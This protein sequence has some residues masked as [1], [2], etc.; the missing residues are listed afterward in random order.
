MAYTPLARAR[1]FTEANLTTVLNLY[2]DRFNNMT[3]TD[4]NLIIEPS[5]PG[6]S[7]T[8]YQT[9]GQL[10]IEYKET[11]N[12]NAFR[13]HNYLKNFSPSELTKYLKFWG[14]TYFTP[15]AKVNSS[16]NPILIFVELSKLILNSTSLPTKKY[17]F[18]TFSA[19]YFSGSLDILKNVLKDHTLYI[20]YDNHTDEFFVSIDNEDKLQTLIDKIEEYFPIP[21][22][23]MSPL[24]LFERYS[25]ENFSKFFLNI[26]REP[27]LESHNKIIYG[28]PGTGKSFLLQEKAIDLFDDDNFNRITFYNGYTYGQ[29]VGAF[30][31]KPIYKDLT[32]NKIEHNLRTA[33]TDEHEPII[34]YEFIAGPFIELLVKALSDESSNFCLIIEEIN[35]T[36]VD[37]VFGNIFQL[38]DR[39][40]NGRSSYTIIPSV[41]LLLYIKENTPTNIYN[42]I[43]NNGLYLPQ[44]FYLWATMNSADQGVFPMD[45]A[46]KRRWDFEYIGLN[47]NESYMNNLFIN[48]GNNDYIGYNDFRH[49]VNAKLNTTFNIDEDKM[50]APFFV[51]RRD[52]EEVVVAGSANKWVL[53]EEIFISKI[54][55]YLKDDILR[56]SRNET[57]FLFNTF[58]EI[59]E[60]YP[61]LSIIDQT[62]L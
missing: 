56:H 14:M 62:S 59:V 45:T 15:N 21:V 18:T 32:N 49:K 8:H 26:I 46:F 47:E 28:A 23:Y 6:Y 40:E 29:F 27:I 35:R 54:V 31:P 24:C 39:D 41:E 4:A 55:M 33:I 12:K 20:E 1:N 38:L 61:T 34:T 58:S 57:I 50:I 44:N 3:W 51:N 25:E 37:A 22:G 42:D 5:F 10:G 17:N 43:E 2:E 9:Y 53:K 13:V 48:L 16:D 19:A 52:F 60:N 36:K 11:G 7:R 30:K